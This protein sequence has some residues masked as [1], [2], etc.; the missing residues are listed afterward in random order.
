MTDDRRFLIDEMTEARAR[1]AASDFAVAPECVLKAALD[2][3][4]E[5]DADDQAARVDSACHQIATA[6]G[7]RPKSERP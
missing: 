6:R 3:F 2:A 4:L 5:L 7:W 1:D